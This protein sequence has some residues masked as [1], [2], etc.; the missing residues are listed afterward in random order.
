[1]TSLFKKDRSKITINTDYDMILMIEKGITGGIC[2][3]THRCAK[4]NNKHMK[5]HDK[6]V[7]SSYIEYLNANNLYGWPMSQKLPANGFKWV[8]QKKLWKFN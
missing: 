7:D 6:S 3:A 8:K 2:Q 1:M 5:N 4:A